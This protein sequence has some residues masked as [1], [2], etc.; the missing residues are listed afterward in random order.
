MAAVNS[1]RQGPYLRGKRLRNN[2]FGAS[3]PCFHYLIEHTII[4]GVWKLN[5]ASAMV[6]VQEVAKFLNVASFLFTYIHDGGGN[7]IVIRIW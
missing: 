4:V 7:V 3:S 5:I 6:S 1:N 2:G